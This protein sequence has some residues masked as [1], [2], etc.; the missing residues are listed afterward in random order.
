MAGSGWCTFYE[1]HSS[2][3]GAWRYIRYPEVKKLH[4]K[5]TYSTNLVGL[6][7]AF[8][9]L[10]A[11]VIDHTEHPSWNKEAPNYLDDEYVDYSSRSRSFRGKSAKLDYNELEKFASTLTHLEIWLDDAAFSENEKV[12]PRPSLDFLNLSTYQIRWVSIT[13]KLVLKSL[14]E[15]NVDGNQQ[16]H[17]LLRFYASEAKI[18]NMDHKPRKLF[19]S[20][21]WN[22]YREEKGITGCELQGKSNKPQEAKAVSVSN[23]DFEIPT[24]EELFIGTVPS[25][26]NDHWIMEIHKLFRSIEAERERLDTISPFCVPG[27][28]YCCSSMDWC[29][30]PEHT[31][32][33]DLLGKLYKHQ[34]SLAI[35]GDCTPYWA[36][37]SSVWVRGYC[38]Y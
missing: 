7:N 2:D 30:I 20:E 3:G 33:F 19:T 25:T 6:H 15:Y 23:L 24:D 5:L 21:T 4:L 9:N 34:R 35:G 26:S 27:I 11:L 10:T 18:A 12:D 16:Y 8:P 29:G 31:K 36:A 28:R 13:S 1:V 22:E 32:Y 17:P 14:D 37:D 38:K